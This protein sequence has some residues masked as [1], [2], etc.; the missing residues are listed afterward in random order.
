MKKFVF[1]SN[2]PAPHQVRYCYALQKYYDTT[3]LFYERQG[4]KPDYWKVDLGE[5]CIILPK[6][7][8]I[9]GQYLTFS[10]LSYLRKINP[11][12]IMLGGFPI[13]ANWIA[14]VWGRIHK[15][16]IVMFSERSRTKDGDLRKRGFRSRLFEFLYPKIDLLLA[17]A[18]D[19]IPQFK[20]EF[21]WHYNVKFLP[22]A[23][24][25]DRYYSHPYRTEKSGYTYIFANR[26]IPIYNPLLA[27]KI[28]SKIH[29][30]FPDSKLKLCSDGELKEECANFIVN[31]G[32][33]NAVSFLDEIKHWDELDEIYKTSDI[34]ILPAMFSNGNF[35]IIEAQAS[36]M[37]IVISNKVMGTN[38]IRGGFICVPDVDS[39]VENIL[40]YVNTPGIFITHAKMNR[41]DVHQYGCSAVARCTKEL[42]DQ[43]L[44]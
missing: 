18:E 23:S 43:E 25:I 34:M 38:N 10:H 9:K 39:F 13:P 5:R 3:F 21:K 22:Y 31:N 11:D 15:K 30:M 12:I 37:G 6:S 20:D 32:L 36:G 2:L 17:T 7:I 28:F 29:S 44:L 16:K 19:T 41:E 40:H 1:I 26:L 8:K 27:L 4:D 33:D 14:Y 35:T 24:D 42:F